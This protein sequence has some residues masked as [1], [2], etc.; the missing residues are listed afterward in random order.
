MLGGMH[1]QAGRARRRAVARTPKVLE[2]VRRRRSRALPV[3]AGLVIVLLIAG[4]RRAPGSSSRTYGLE[5]APDGTV[6]VTTA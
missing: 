1:G 5:E 6:R 4:R 2:P 3:V